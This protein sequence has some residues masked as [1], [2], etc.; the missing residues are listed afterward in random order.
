MEIF[1]NFCVCFS[2]LCVSCLQKSFEAVCN[3]VINLVVSPLS[4]SL[5]CVS[6][7]Q[8]S[9][10]AVCDLLSILLCV[11]VCVCLSLSLFCLSHVHK[12]P[13]K[14]FAICCQSCCVSSLSLSLSL[15]L[16]SL[17]HV[18][19]NPL[20]QFAICCQSCCVSL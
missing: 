11:C 12:N 14:Q 4:L 10:E 7:S 16:F 9:F 5:F 6:C 17:P 8:K 13:L 19:K 15:S 1:Q 3:F 18:H 20:K 2:L